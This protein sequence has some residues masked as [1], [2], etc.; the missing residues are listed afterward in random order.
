MKGLK[1]RKDA[2]EARQK[3]LESLAQTRKRHFEEGEQTQSSSRKRPKKTG[4]ETMLYLQSK[5]EKDYE[6]RKEELK[7]KK[8][9]MEQQKE[10]DLEATR[11]QASA[12]ENMAKMLEHFQTQQVN[13]QQQMLEQQ[14]QY[15]MMMQQQSQL[16]LSV[17]EKLSKN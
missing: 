7:M 17:V 10:L 1:D 5:A 9:E 13:M 8:E 15:Q 16:F 6:L 11:K 14:Q 3:A 2:E 12:T 4:S